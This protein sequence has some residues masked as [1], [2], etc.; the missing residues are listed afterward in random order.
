MGIQFE[1]HELQHFTEAEIWPILT[2]YETQ[3]IYAVEKTETDQRIVFDFNLVRLEKPFS[4][5]FFQDFT[6]EECQ[7]YLSLL[8]K[9]Y[10][11]GA[12]QKDWLIG[13]ALGE[14]IAEDHMLRI[15]EFHVMEKFR[16]K[17]VGR[18][19]METVISKAKRDQFPLILLE[20]QN[21]NVNA[22]R[23]YHRMGFLLES[24]D[25]SPPHYTNWE[26]TGVTQVAFY[27]KLKLEGR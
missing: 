23:F 27:M 11:F 4:D 22:I 21:T 20:T 24:I 13:F 15:W 6:P 9:G 19:L 5:S 18:G 3:E 16:R 1:I 17:G 2:G 26:G 25:C 7:R 12:Y 8:P 10:C 14:V